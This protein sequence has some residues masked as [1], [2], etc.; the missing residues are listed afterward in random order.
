MMDPLWGSKHRHDE[1]DT[2]DNPINTTQIND[3]R[4]L[5]SYS[6]KLVTKRLKIV[7]KSSNEQYLL[8][9]FTNEY[10]SEFVRKRATITACAMFPFFLFL[11][12]LPIALL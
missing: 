11:P 10:R 3:H 7:S 6:I 4:S 8:E 9:D 2:V 12:L 5:K 1:Y